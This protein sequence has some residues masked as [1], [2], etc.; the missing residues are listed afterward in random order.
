MPQ[1]LIPVG[2]AILSVTGPAALA[3]SG[4][5]VIAGALAG[6]ISAVGG[7]AAGLVGVSAV[8]GA[9]SLGAAISSWS[10]V[11]LLASTALRPPSVGK[12]QAGAQT[13]FQAD[14]AAGIPLIL[15]RSGTAGKVLHGNTSGQANKNIALFYLLALSAGPIQNVESLTASDFPVVLNGELVTAPPQYANAMG[16]RVTY[17][18]KPEPAAVYPPAVDPGW[19][20][21]WTAAHKTSGVATAWWT[22]VFDTKSYPTGMPKPLFVVN[23]PAVYDPRNDDTVPG[24]AGPQRWDDETTWSFAGN[25]NPFLQGL[26]WCI[27]RRDNGKVTFGVG[28][29]I[30][31]IDVAAFIEGANVC[32]ANAWRVGGEVLSSDRKW[33]VL[34]TILQAGG[35]EP[36]RLAG[37]LSCYVRTPRVTLATITGKNLV[38]DASITGTKRRRDRFNQIIPT[39][40]S[41]DHAWDMV[42]AG[43]VTIDQY[44]Q[45]DGGLRSREASY[46][47]VQQAKQAAELAAYDLLDAREFE[48]VVLPLGPAYSALLP[49]DCILIDEPEF[50]M[51]AQPVLIQTRDLDP[52]TGR[53][54][55][56]CRSETPGKHEYAL[57]RTPNPPP[58]PGLTPL[59]PAYVSQPDVGSWAAIGGVLA[60]ADGAQVPAIIV[61]GQTNDPNITNVL[62]DYAL[63][64]SPG[65]FGDTVTAEAPSSARRIELR[66][67]V[68]GGTYHVAVRYRSVRNVEGTLYLDLGL[69][70]AGNLI[71]YGVTSIGGQT[72]DELIEQLN[73]T[74][75]L[76]LETSEQAAQNAADILELQESGVDS[77]DYRV[78][79]IGFLRPGG[80]TFQLSDTTLFAN[81]SQS[82]GQYRTS[83]QTNFDSQSAAITNEQT[84]RANADTALATNIT[85]VNTKVDGNTASITNLQSSVNGLN[86]QWVLSVSSTGPGYARVAGVKVAANPAV[87]SIAFAADQIGFTNGVDN[88][89]PLAVVGNKVIA[90]NFQA[91]DIKANTITA[92][93]IVGGAVTAT[94]VY[95]AGVQQNFVGAAVEDLRFDYTT[96]VPGS[97]HSISVY[98]E[99]A[100]MTAS[101]AGTVFNLYCDGVL[102]GSG[103]LYCPGSWGG[104][105]LTFPVAHIPAGGLHT[106]QLQHVGTTG[107]GTSRVNRTQV[108]LTELKK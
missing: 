66:A 30:D 78:D 42:P 31:A 4:G 17:G 45:A 41:E 101:A 3:L 7:F 57:G 86:A 8:T 92:E 108:I 37:R 36:T 93:K 21:E 80:A 18:L 84:V 48:P 19:I 23:G 51:Q 88:V 81:N 85:N 83:I 10:T 29:P 52:A 72:P 27:G 26:T 25:A 98:G 90:T 94:V 77:A 15:G 5:G 16:L 9:L 53:V 59:D 103:S 32:D 56:T 11:A 60:G 95:Q 24:G 68:S 12:G 55:I 69:V 106:Y 79:L 64:L 82:W 107:S 100:T 58:I 105:G 91:D 40:R 20:P 14:P 35:G 39:Y 22:L 99:L 46:P 65:V 49:G 2:M 62:V 102:I 33:D 75:A 38:G 89:F 28:A 1:L 47:L 70:T 34:R 43:P 104:T 44:V 97:V 13:D 6:A 87:S 50:G 63:Q 61:T 54:T 67:V 74:T 73:D 76:G 71:S 96:S